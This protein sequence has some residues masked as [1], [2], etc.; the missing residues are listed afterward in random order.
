VSLGN[1]ILGEGS[2][3]RPGGVA[4]GSYVRLRVTDTGHG[5][6]PDIMKRIFDPYFTTKEVGKGTGLGLAVVHGIV[7]GCGGGITVSSEAGQGSTFEVYFPRLDTPNSMTPSPADE[8]LPAGRQ[9]RILIVDDEQSVVEVIGEMLAHSGYRVSA[10]TSSLEALELFR[11]KPD[12]F[13]LVMTDMTMPNMTGDKLAAELL[14]I[15]PDIPII[16]CTGFSEFI[17]EDRA[18]SLGIRALLLKPLVRKELTQAVRR[19]LENNREEGEGGNG[20]HPGDR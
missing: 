9:E 6:S 13:D 12:Q 16:L 18:K 17:D 7:K 19:V 2:P 1:C 8:S 10:R 3:G 5:M 20:S 11:A 4:L 15:R 14:Q